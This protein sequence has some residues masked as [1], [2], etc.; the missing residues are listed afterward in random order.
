MQAQEEMLLYLQGRPPGQL[1]FLGHCLGHLQGTGI[2]ILDYEQIASSP[3]D[4]SG[5]E[6]SR[7]TSNC[8]LSFLNRLDL[9]VH[10]LLRLN[11][12]RQIYS[13]YQH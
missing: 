6:R 8:M 9:I 12:H 11:F 13:K 4:C 7:L 1:D 5:A 3:G 2:I 10:S